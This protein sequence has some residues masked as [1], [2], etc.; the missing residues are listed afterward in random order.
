MCVDLRALFPVLVVVKMLFPCSLAS[1]THE[2]DAFVDHDF[3]DC[4]DPC[5]NLVDNNCRILWLYTESYDVEPPEV[6]EPE[7]GGVGAVDKESPFRQ[8]IL[9]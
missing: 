4:N 8:G 1:T 2:L 5:R 7:G 3:E 9:R 6:E